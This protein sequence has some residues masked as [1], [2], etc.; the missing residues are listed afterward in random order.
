MEQRKINF[1]LVFWCFIALFLGISFA[2]PIFDGNL[3]YI[4]IVILGFAFLLYILKKYK[5]KIFPLLIVFFLGT[6]LYFVDYNVFTKG[7]YNS[8]Y[9]NVSGRVSEVLYNGI[10]LDNCVIEKDKIKLIVYTDESFE[11]GD[12]IIFSGTINKLNLYQNGYFNSSLYRQGVSHSANLSTFEIVKNNKNLAESF[13]EEVKQ[14]LHSVMSSD[15]AN[16]CYAVLFGDKT[17]LDYT[18]YSYFK[19]A[20]I[21]HLLA[22]SGLHIGFFSALIFFF[23]K[24]LRNRYVKFFILFVILGLYCYLCSFTPS[25]VRAS[26]MCLILFSAEMFGKNYDPLTCIGISGILI[27]IFAP[28]YALDLGFRLSYF[29]VLSIFVLYKSFYNMFRKIKIPKFI[30]TSLAISVSTQIGIL[31]FLINVFGEIAIFSI[32]TNLIAIPIFQVAY[33]VLMLGLILSFIAPVFY[34]VLSVAELLIYFIE[35]LANFVSSIPYSVITVTSIGTFTTIAYFISVF[36]CSRFVNINKLSKIKIC[37]ILLL[38]SFLLTM[39]V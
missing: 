5:I 13:R 30:A 3:V 39:F 37:S 15:N 6:T 33:T 12:I 10:V 19:N 9:T 28:L 36:V 4:L 22:V 38:S 29:C 27:L 8:N 1:R 32:L 18:I 14:K 35:I 7:V 21:A 11:V 24:I 34:F 16:I 31:P 20:G 17:E 25:V 2:K 23:L 26:L